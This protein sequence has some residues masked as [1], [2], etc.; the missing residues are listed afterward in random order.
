VKQQEAQ[1]PEE[2][3]V[4]SRSII[5]LDPPDHTR[6]RKLVPPSFTGRGIQALRAVFVVE[7]QVSGAHTHT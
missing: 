2:F 7:F 5:S 1:T 3:R 6:L 4:L